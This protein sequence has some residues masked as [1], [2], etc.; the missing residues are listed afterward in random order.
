MQP[1]QTNLTRSEVAVLRY[2][3]NLRKEQFCRSLK[4]I[5]KAC[6]VT[7]KTV[8]RANRRFMFLG[9]LLWTSG[10]SASWR[11]GRKKGQANRY[12]LNLMGF[13]GFD[14]P[15]GQATLLRR[16]TGKRAPA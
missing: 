1:K 9:I 7:V 10:N 14:V 12:H 6:G 2:Y 11:P 5:A 16:L 3:R 4:T 13:Y 8:Q 15:Q